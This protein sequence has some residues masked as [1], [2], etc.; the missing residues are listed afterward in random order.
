MKKRL[1]TALLGILL[2]SCMYADSALPLIHNVMAYEGTTLAG[3]WN[4]I[5]DVQEEGYYDY[6]MNPTRWGGTHRMT[7]CSSTKERC[8]S[9]AECIK[10]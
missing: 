4:Y 3:D 5:V 7:S 2:A 9:K 8:S 1:F 10:R 6:R